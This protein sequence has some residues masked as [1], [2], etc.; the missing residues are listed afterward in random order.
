M[1]DVSLHLNLKQK[2]VTWSESPLYRAFF[3][4]RVRIPYH[5][6][7]DAGTTRTGVTAQRADSVRGRSL[8]CPLSS[9]G[10]TPPNGVGAGSNPAGE[11]I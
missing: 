4:N 5:G 1:F 6:R 7:S 8:L 11:L 10:R 3:M 2:P 9:N